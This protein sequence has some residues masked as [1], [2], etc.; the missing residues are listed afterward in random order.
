MAE[1]FV[2]LIAELKT[3]DKQ[4]VAGMQ[5]AE[6]TVTDSGRKM[7]TSLDA[8]N[9]SSIDVGTS[10][11]AAGQVAAA[12]GGQFGGM[13]GQVLAAGS[14]FKSLGAAAFGLPGLL[15]AAGAAAVALILK[16]TAASAAA[17]EFAQSQRELG[18]A[19]LQSKFAEVSAG[20]KDV[21]KLQAGRLG[22]VA[23]I[24]AAIQSTSDQIRKRQQTLTDEQKIRQSLT[25]AGE[26]QRRADLNDSIFLHKKRIT[27]LEEIKNIQESNLVALEEM[28]RRE[29]SKGELKAAQEAR[30]FMAG[31]VKQANQVIAARSAANISAIQGA[32][33]S[34]GGA[35]LSEFT[36]DPTQKRVQE[37]LEQRAGI[38]GAPSASRSF[39]TGTR[40]AAQFRFGGTGGV[41]GQQKETLTEQKK[42]NAKLD[43]IIKELRSL[44]SVAQTSGLG[45]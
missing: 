33:I 5:K 9:K 15:I 10:L 20:A 43:D 26:G 31:M 35:K 17:K 13:A 16:Y 40:S 1:K 34:T 41:I 21:A 25:G 38:D 19:L 3:D 42:G 14:A 29:R 27:Q 6:K 30:A 39:S 37:L 36:T 7:Q 4:L 2:E 45:I 44:L 11:G 18:R 12:A 32:L 8:V 22:D 24:K 23:S 28:R